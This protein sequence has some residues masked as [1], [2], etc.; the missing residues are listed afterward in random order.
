MLKKT[1][2]YENYNGEK[3]SEDF[4][5]S[6]DK[7]ELIELEVT[8]GEGGYSALLTEI[9]AED[10]RAK[11]F[12]TFKKII[13]MAVG[14]KSADG[15]EFEKSPEITRKFQQCPAYSELL[16][17]LYTVE[18]SAVEFV[19]GIV[20]AGLAADVKNM[21]TLQLPDG[22]KDVVQT[23]KEKTWEDYTRTDLILMAEDEFNKLIDG[24]PM[25][26]MPRPLLGVVMERKAKANRQ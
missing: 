2:A 23:E 6:I 26:G 4:Y 10:D 20:P 1:I 17:E 12:E 13:N 21:E 9:I 16:M 8:S 5:F 22:S 25:T 15:R 3:V 11:M 7:A 19:S 14:R 18:G 24:I